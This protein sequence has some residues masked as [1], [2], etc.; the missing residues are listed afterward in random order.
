MRISDFHTSRVG[1]SLFLYAGSEEDGKESKS[2]VS[3]YLVGF[4]KRVVLCTIL[5]F[6]F[7]WVLEQDKDKGYLVG[8]YRNCFV[9]S[10]QECLAP[11]SKPLLAGASGKGLLC[12]EL[13]RKCGRHEFL[14]MFCMYFNSF[15]RW[16]IVLPSHK[17]MHAK[18][19]DFVCCAQQ[20][21]WEL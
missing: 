13:D 14:L 15:I 7:K 8:F 19:L 16:T 20:S 21:A 5:V 18:A 9:F 12:R 3:G 11:S 10:L 4:A 6:A 1:W 17:T 2:E